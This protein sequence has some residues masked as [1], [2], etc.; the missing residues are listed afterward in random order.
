MVKTSATHGVCSAC[1]YDPACIYEAGSNSVILQ[2]EQFEMAPPVPVARPTSAQPRALAGN[3]TD[4]NGYA[5]LCSN[6]ENRE[7][8][9]YPKP[10]GGVWRCE[11]YV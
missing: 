1:K 3:G 10:E 7:T 9:V 2:C 4:T 5:G 6:C 11:E 8:C